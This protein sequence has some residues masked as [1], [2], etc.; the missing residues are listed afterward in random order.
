[1]EIL[2]IV[3][4]FATLTFSLFLNVRGSSQRIKSE[5]LARALAEELRAA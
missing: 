5:G 3:A 2:V 1:M 4:L